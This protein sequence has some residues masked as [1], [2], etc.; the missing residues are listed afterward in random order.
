MKHKPSRINS[1]NIELFRSIINNEL[2][3]LRN[4]LMNYRGKDLWSV[5]CSA[6]D[7]VETST[8][9]LSYRYAPEL[10]NDPY[11]DSMNVIFY[12]A[13]VDMLYEGVSQLHRVVFGELCNKTNSKLLE[14]RKGIFSNIYCC[15]DDVS[16][17]KQIRAIFGEHSVNLN[18]KEL[19]YP[20][21][22]RKKHDKERWFASW[23]YSANKGI[24]TEVFIYSNK[25]G[26]R[27]IPFSINLSEIELF[28]VE[29][30]SYILQ[31]VD[32]ARKIENN[33]KEKFK[34]EEWPSFKKDDYK[35][36]I[37]FLLNENDRRIGSDRY[38]NLLY[39]LRIILQS[40]L[41]NAIV[42]ELKR[43]A[44]EMLTE[45]N[46]AIHSLQDLDEIVS[47][48]RLVIQQRLPYTVSKAY[49]SLAVNVVEKIEDMD[50]YIWK[51]E[52]EAYV[53]P[54]VKI[55]DDMTIEDRYVIVTASLLRLEGRL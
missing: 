28:A 37:G 29:T 51:D 44:Y 4:Q 15:K 54:I 7:W 22:E 35:K 27:A 39:E 12:I 53:A 6:M 45:L 42:K 36:H 16:F 17:F 49:T 34:K 24:P 2:S 41:D 48:E 1:D 52:L 14:D 23:S 38:R 5:V 18:L 13:A 10:H 55:D 21:E 19:L 26:V 3:L 40:D 9:W 33:L 30:N 31:I 8:H 43:E 20:P 11:C 47:T 50:Y 32:K 46:W 25:P